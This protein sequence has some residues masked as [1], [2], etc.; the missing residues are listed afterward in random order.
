MEL[1]GNVV[2]GGDGYSSEWHEMAVKE[3]GLLNLPTTA[4]ALPYLRQDF[5]K[6][7]FAKTGVLSNVELGSRFE[8]Y[9]EQYILSI[10]VEA[11]LV[12][13][14]AK[15]LIYPASTHYLADLAM[16]SSSMSDLGVEMDNSI[17][18]SIATETNAMVA[19]VAQLEKAL[20]KHDFASTEEHMNFCANDI[21]ALM[22]T[23]R[24]HVDA[25]EAEVADDL[26]PLPKYRE[27]LFIK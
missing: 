6:D 1:H 27:M 4:D 5:I 8:V 10:E 20:A 16:T 3:R 2:F 22:V 12:I 23:I 7:L 17:P 9:A 21:R 14:M 13:E 19:A 26:W 24:S 11:K 18:T 25:L 15:T